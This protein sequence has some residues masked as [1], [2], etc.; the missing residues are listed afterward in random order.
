L[1]AGRAAMGQ[2]S[3]DASVYFEALINDTNCPAELRVEARF[4]YSDALRQMT[5]SDTNNA[6][7]ILATNILSQLCPMSATNEAGALAWSETG[8]CDLQ[9]G[10]LDDATNAYAQAMN[11]PAAGAG[12]RSRAQVGLGLVLEK[13]AE[14]LPAGDAGRK[15]LL[16]LALNDYLDV[17][18]EKNLRDDELQPDLRWKKEAGL[19]AAPLVGLLND[20]AAER[21]FYAGMQTALPQLKDAL[22]KKIAALPSPKN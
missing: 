3:S 22:D 10:A 4:A 2:F 9:L 8:D 1:M 11:S 14:R 18:Y 12:L 21:K 6:N 15:I 19:H 13:M 7:L 17:F 16:A 20:A 5:S